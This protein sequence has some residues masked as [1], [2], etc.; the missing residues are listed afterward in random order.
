[1]P[2]STQP[3]LLIKLRPTGPWRIGPDSGARDRVDRVYHSDTLYSAVT[4]ALAQFDLRDQWLAATAAAGGEPAVRFTSCFP[5]QGDTL[6]VPPPRHM[7]PPAAATRLRFKSTRFVPV[8]MVRALVDEKPLAEDR[9]IIDPASECLLRADRASQG[10][11]FRVAIRTSASVDRLNHGTVVVHSVAVLE[12]GERA[13]LW[14]LAVFRDEGARRTWKNPIQAAFRLLADSGFGGERSNGFGHSQIPLFQDCKLPDILLRP[15]AT[16]KA[17]AT[18]RLPLAYA[19]ASEIGREPVRESSHEAVAELPADAPGSLAVTPGPEPAAESLPASEAMVS[20]GAPVVPSAEPVAEG[21]TESSAAAPVAETVPASEAMVSEG[22]PI[23]PAA[24]P[25]A[26]SARETSAAEPVAETVPGSSVAE[27][28]RAS[29]AMVSEGAPVPPAAEP[30]AESATETSAAE[31]VAETVPVSSATEPLPASE[32]MV[33]EGAPV[34][35]AAEPVPESATQTPATKYVE[36]IAT[37][38]LA[39][40]SLPQSEAMVSEGA[41]AFESAW[42]V[43]SLFSPGPDDEVDWNGGSYSVVTRGGRIESSER[44]GGQKRLVRMIS[45]GSVLRSPASPAGAAPNVAPEDFPHPV[46]RSGHAVSIAIPWRV[47]L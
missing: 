8:E 31:H 41:P 29:Q 34:M 30:V 36:K 27:P 6:F 26:E 3:A 46:F 38:S 18:S 42:W 22:S 15:P 45:E 23:E 14:T 47:N 33:S 10:G 21:V 35:P 1:M 19:R 24:E 32:A 2:S 39:A 28:L 12:F 20:E 43:L 40:E 11:P 25:A 44:W 9:W 17:I 13:G 37:G 5:F 4:A 7:W 16:I